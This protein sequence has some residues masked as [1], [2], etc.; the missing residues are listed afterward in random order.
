MKIISISRYNNQLEIQLKPETALLVNNK[1]LFIPQ[2]TDDVRCRVCLLARISRLGRNIEQ[3]FAS[4]YYDAT[5]LGIDFMAYDRLAEARR[6][7]LS[8]APWIA[9]DNS[10]AISQWTDKDERE[11][12][13]LIFTIN[14]LNN[15]ELVNKLHIDGFEYSLTEAIAQVSQYFKLCTGDIVA[16]SSDIEPIKM[17]IDTQISINQEQ[18]IEESIISMNI[19]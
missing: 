19:K 4:R 16:V 11:Y 10:L 5:A 18:G 13:N 17:N 9:F 12:Q 6:Q 3:R 8:V 1:P 15:G 14:R 2:F 7:G